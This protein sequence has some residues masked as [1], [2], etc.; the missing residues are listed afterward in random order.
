MDVAVL[1]KG[2][3]PRYKTCGGGI[4]AKTAEL[5]PF[6]IEP[7]TERVITKVRV[8]SNMREPFV[9]ETDKPLVYNVGR[10]RFDSFLMEKA[11]EQGAKFFQQEEVVDVSEEKD[12]VDI[13]T[14]RRKIRGSVVVGA[15]GALSVVA[16]YLYAG[17]LTFQRD[18]GLEAEVVVRAQ[19]LERLQNTI[20][21]DWGTMPSGYAWVFPKEDHLSIGAGGPFELA[22]SV[23]SYYERFLK[24][25][26]E[27]GLVRHCEVRRF[28]G[29]LLPTGSSRNAINTRRSVLVGDAAG[30]IDPVSGEGI[31]YA[32][33]SARIASSLIKE[34]LRR[35]TLNLD[36][37]TKEIRSELLEEIES[38]GSLVLLFNSYP[39][40]FH[41]WFQRSDAMARAL[42]GDKSYVSMKEE[43]GKVQFLWPAIDGITTRITRRKLRNYSPGVQ[44]D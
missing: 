38:A 19:D 20:L 40:F 1:E 34:G 41:R 23:K 24:L 3:F 44:V 11:A 35:K 18:I 16:K 26:R 42:R 4:Q 14:D 5:F 37:Y 13:G 8:T 15:D 32:V 12:F 7:V 2:R 10:D 29:H 27:E 28:S 36:M 6:S 22:R 17:E 9:R 25:L 21:I 43:L 39:R 33:R 30:L 31:F